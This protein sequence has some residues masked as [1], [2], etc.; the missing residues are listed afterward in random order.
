MTARSPR[1]QA[2]GLT[3][4]AALGGL[5]FGYDTAVISGAIGSI[6]LNFIDPLQLSET[7]RSSLSGFTI[8]SALFGCVIGGA[9]AG[10]LAD[11]YGRK[12]TLVFAALMF[13]ICSIGSAV[14][15]LGLG[16]IGGMGAGALLPFNLYRIIGGIGV[17]VASLVSPL[18]IAEIAPKHSRG[19]LVS[20]YQMA[21]VVGI[22]GVYF[23]NWAIAGLGNSEW[24]HRVGWR[25]MFA[26]EALPSMLFLALLLGAPDTPRW[27]V[28]QRR[29]TEALALL[30]RLGSEADPGATLAEIRAS[31]VV[32]Q[33]R[34]FAYGALVVVV[35]ILLSVFQQ[36]VGINAVL[37]YAPL[38]FQNM[39]SS[40]DSALLQTVIVG[41]AN[42]VF[43]L[44]ATFK[45][46]SWGRRPLMLWGALIMAASMLTLGTLFASGH[47][48]LAALVAMIVYI[49][50]FSLS[51]GP[52]VWILLSEIFPNAIKARAM[53]I[54]VA[55]QWIANL[56]V[57]WSFKVLD[58]NS[59]LNAAFNHGF[60][61]WIYG[62]M[63]LLAA[64]FVWRYVPETKGR[65]LEQMQH[66]W[67]KA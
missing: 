39:G 8:S 24:L 6:D 7:A 10:W 63:S 47:M 56:A 53:A 62:A 22:V 57:S 49:A 25:W 58:G 64:L 5:L 1:S 65:S 26:S 29:D 46:D 14:P 12:R 9:G 66:L 34:L 54:A 31:L 30:H 45:V 20:L 59:L 37:Y 11:R 3:L 51:W 67:R 2:T 42:M 61:Y 17:G 21:I 44:V 19:K 16:T 28:M 18:Y 35:G 60:A 23:I 41:L 52:V 38:M 55:A 36:L 50:G 27:L 15:E 48:G 33:E 43:T 40:T 32:S 4:I 13:L